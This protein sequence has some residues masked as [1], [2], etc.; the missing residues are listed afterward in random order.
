MGGKSKIKADKL[1]VP[2]VSNADLEKS[3]KVLEDM[4]ERKR[5]RSSMLHSLKDKKQQDQYEKWST[6]D[7]FDILC[8]WHADRAVNAASSSKTKRKVEVDVQNKAKYKM[9][10]MKQMVDEWGEEKA[11]MK[12][13][14]C[15]RYADP[16]TGI[17]DDINGEYKVTLHSGERTQSD[18]RSTEL[19]YLHA[20]Q[21]EAASKEIDAAL[22]DMSE[23]MGLTDLVNPHREEP[24]RESGASGRTIAIAVKTEPS[25]EGADSKTFKTLRDDP[26]RAL[27]N[28]SDALTSLKKWFH[29]SK[30][31]EFMEMLHESI[32]KCIPLFSRSFS[33]IET[34]AV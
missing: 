11:Q 31:Q 15:K 27:R 17:N 8:A 20:D 4:A 3:R 7:K 24:W 19:E 32:T 2:S 33:Q 18:K 29:E 21:S 23:A 12:A 25:V 30:H 22:N 14:H 5:S 9:M 34:I 26:R 28:T 1:T 6:N 10:I 13:T 16:D